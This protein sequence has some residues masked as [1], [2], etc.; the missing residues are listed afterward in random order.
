MSESAQRHITDVTDQLTKSP[1]FRRADADDYGIDEQ[2]DHPFGLST[3]TPRYRRPHQN[4][5]ISCIAGEQRIEHSE[6][7]HK[8]SGPFTTAHHL[9]L[10][11]QTLRDRQVSNR[12]FVGLKQ[13]SRSV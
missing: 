13:G 3:I 10:C 1:I 12:S 9:D 5:L 11:S 6:K 4:V 2:T 8:E 7:N